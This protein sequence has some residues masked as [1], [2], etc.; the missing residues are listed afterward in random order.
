MI[1]SASA[2]PEGNLSNPLVTGQL[3]MVEH[4]CVADSAPGVHDG[5]SIA[6][7]DLTEV[8]RVE[9]STAWGTSM[10]MIEWYATANTVPSTVV[11]RIGELYLSGSN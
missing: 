9:G 2:A 3:L 11:Y 7:V 1:D 6:W 10:E 4:L 8:G 5:Y